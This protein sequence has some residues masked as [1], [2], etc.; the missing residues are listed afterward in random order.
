MNLNTEAKVGLVSAIGFVI[1]AWMIIWVGHIDF[2]NKGYP[3]QAVFRHV[4]GLVEGNPVRYAGVEVGK[5]TG[6]IVKPKGIVVTMQLKPGVAIPEGSKFTIGSMGLM[7]EKFVEI[8]PN[9]L[10]TKTLAPGDEVLGVDPQRLDDLFN[11]ADKLIKDMQTLVNSLNEVVGSEQSKTALKQTIL[12]LRAITGNLEVFTASIQRM[13]VYSEQDV[14][15]MA[16]NLRGVSERLLS[17]SNQADAFMRQFAADGK[18]GKELKDSVESINRTA[19]KVEKMATTLEKEV[20][21][22]QTIQSL[23]DTVR[24]VREASEKANKMLT[25]VQNIKMEGGVE[26]LGAQDTY[27]ANMDLRIRNGA[28]S[29]LQVGVNDIGEGD[30]ANVQIGK[31]TGDITSRMGLFDGKAGIGLDHQLGSHAKVSV[32]MFDPNDTK[33]KLR[34]E[35]YLG[36]SAVVIQKSDIKDD[37]QPTY[38]GFRKNF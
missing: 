23:K 38:V 34:G 31:Q 6:V 26:V 3:V 33:I 37:Q 27:Q 4:D 7:G 30:K 25:K 32:E 28:G 36:D 10:A 11:T 16:E 19:Q 15:S 21:N 17:A 35:Y 29:F 14:I 9:P 18:T 20:T 24:N 1:L 12:N 8:I 5:V 13:A 22:P 2:S